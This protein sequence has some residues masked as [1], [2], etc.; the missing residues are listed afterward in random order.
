MA[1]SENFIKLW[2]DQK[3]CARTTAVIVDEA[4]CIHD[5]GD[6]FR[7][8]YKTLEMFRSYTGQEVPIVSNRPFWG[9]DVGCGRPNLLFL[10]RTVSN[11]KNPVLDLLN[12]LAEVLSDDIPLEAIDK[13]LVYFDSEQNC[14]DGAD[15]FREALPAHLHDSVYNFSGTMSEAAKEACRM[16]C[17][18]PDVKITVIIGSPKCPQTTGT[19]IFLVPKWA[20]RP[21][22]PEVGTAVQAVQHLKRQEKVK[23]EPKTHTESRARLE[24]TLEAFINS[25]VAETAN[26]RCSHK[27]IFKFF[28]PRTGLSTFTSLE[29]TAPAFVGEVSEGSAQELS[30]IVMDLPN[31]SPPRDR[32]CGHCNSKLL[33]TFQPSHN[34]DHRLLQFSAEFIH[35]IAAPSSRPTS[36]V[37]VH[38]DD[39]HASVVTVDFERRL[40]PSPVPKAD[41]DDLRELLVSWR[42]E[43]HKKRGSS[44]FLSADVALP[45]RQLESLISSSGKF[46]TH[47]VIGKLQILTVV[48]NWDFATDEDFR[49]V[50]AIIS[51]WRLRFTSTTPKSQHRAQKRTRTGSV[52]IQPP[53]QPLFSP[54]P[55]TPAQLASTSYHWHSPN[56]TPMP[57]HAKPPD[58]FSSPSISIISRPNPPSIPTCSG[59]RTAQYQMFRTPVNPPQYRHYSPAAYQTP[60]VPNS[61]YISTPIY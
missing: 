44:K 26:G 52:S 54:R 32:C 25:D 40:K 37:S 1:N 17:N 9:L 29:A 16:G 55:T 7:P 18:V 49:D 34:R 35:P 45:P 23:L 2:K 36:P 31:K 59:A 48:K 8:E 50:A 10:T 41:K 30:W 15:T 38:T 47:A 42:T 56:H 19:C 39:S 58:V 5:R 46:L 53:P 60:L 27:F 43:H 24:R 21:I 28:R 14:L 11:P 57:T 3:F 61:N 12:L 13:M 22:P 6:E 33:D 20:F 4:H 51:D